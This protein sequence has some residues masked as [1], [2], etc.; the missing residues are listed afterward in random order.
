MDEELLL[1][2]EVAGRSGVSADTIRHYEKKGVLAP[3]R[4]DGSGYRRYPI[5]TVGRVRTVRL[6]LSIGFTLDELARIFRQKAAGQAP[7]RDVRDLAASKLVALDR[8]IEE[9]TTVRAV[10]VDTLASWNN[11]LRY[12]EGSRCSQGHCGSGFLR[13]PTGSAGRNALRHPAGHASFRTEPPRCPSV[14]A[15]P[16]RTRVSSRTP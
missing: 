1:V 14:P 4:R 10:L 13:H 15:S 8:Q 3:A 12:T 11:D 6:A 7:C 9:P 16:R 5:S 2:G